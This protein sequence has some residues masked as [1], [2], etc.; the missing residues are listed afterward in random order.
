MIKR[1][2]TLVILTT[3]LLS[4]C[5]SENS[6]IS[7]KKDNSFYLI[8]TKEGLLCKGMTRTCISLSIIAS[9]NGVLKPVENA[10]Q[11]KIT[12]PNYPRSLMI[13]LLKP[14]DNSYQATALDNNG[15]LYSLPKN[16]KTNIAWQ[17]LNDLYNANYQ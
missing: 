17:A 5:F 14:A 12:G 2:A 4:G 7:E 8:D 15:R 9:Q 3:T 6:F 11:Q 13:I 16:D 1:L 10:Y